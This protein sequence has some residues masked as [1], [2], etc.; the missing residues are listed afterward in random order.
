LPYGE[1]VTFW[2]LAEIVKAQAGILE[3]DTRE[4]AEA[5]LGGA[6][7][8]VAAD[9]TEA[10]WL[11][12]H[13][14]TLAGLADES[15][16]G[17]EEAF[18]AW[19][20]FL[21]AV[22]EERPLVLVF[23]DLH[24]ADDALL[25][26]VDR[27]VE[28]ASGVPLLV[29]GTA[30]PEL[31]QR[32]S[33][34]GG[35]KPNALT[36]SLSPLSDEDTTRLVQALVER[37][38]LEANKQETL[39]ARAGGN[40]LYAEQYAR[41]LAERGDVTDLPETVQAIIAARLDALSGDEKRLLQDAA[42]IGKVFWLGA[43]EGVGGLLRAQAEELL[44]GL[45]RKEFVQRSR[46]ASIAGESEYAF[47]HLLICDIAYGQ[48]PR[49]ERSQKHQRAAA[50]I[51]SL[52][53]S[54]DQAE[55]L[56]HH[57]LQALEL[58]EAAGVDAEALGEPARHA[59][60]DAG[61]RAAALHAVAAAERFY[62]AALRLWPDGDPE[63]AQLLLRRA[64]P[65]K[66]VGPEDS[67]RLVE[68]LDALL[69]AG[70]KESAAEAELLLAR[71]YW[72]A[73]RH[74]LFDEHTDRA[75]ALLADAP[76]SR[77]SALALMRRG[78]RAYFAGDPATA[79]ELGEQARALI[80]GLGWQEGL[81]QVNSNIGAAR[82]E[83][84][85]P[86]GLKDLERAIEIA[87]AAG[88]L[89]TLSRAYNSIAA[90]LQVLG[91]LD[92]AFEARM[93]GARIAER[94]GLLSAIRWFECVLVDHHY[95]RGDWDEALR[96]ADDFLA[97]V[98]AGESHYGAWQDWFMRAEIRL[99]RG[100]TAAALADA[101]KG[102]AL[103]RAVEDSQAVYFALPAGAHVFALA[104]E[105]EQAL[106][107]A[108]E[109]IDALAG[110]VD[111]QFGVINFP[112]A[113]AAARELGL[114]EELLAAV[115]ARRSTPWIEAL[116]AYGGGDYVRAAEVLEQIGSKPDEAEARL[117]AAEQ[118]VAEGR[119]AEADVQLQQALAFYRSVGA[120]RYVQDCEALLAASA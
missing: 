73:G 41:I 55:M 69:A 77:V 78:T 37:P 43:V 49:A 39:L 81:S 71:S 17:P 66:D 13:L 94:L 42:V 101:E 59:M 83:L 18:S 52:A 48:I 9:E 26:F 70:D 65:V 113:S 28:R 96:M 82:I 15:S 32:R 27:L 20:R 8:G 11:E 117:R 92:A 105:R 10:R 60:R 53:R 97:R 46:G 31:L 54:E 23:E 84:G 14:R 108:R 7:A 109:L 51:E 116:R 4:E 75:F 104:G 45:E 25:D 34:W 89:T 16:A 91:N 63:R 85:E 74:D 87:A 112:L 98:E 50:W 90:A 35:G 3:S 58:A 72:M 19:R 115:E 80:E 57:Y 38:L 30:R 47:G 114:T 24:W 88:A 93:E 33:S 5:K 56:A 86:G 102:L 79:V 111:V 62:D 100:E 120:T 106:P 21:E 6:V 1:G 76:P 44:Y 22:A 95:R 61:D 110:G 119:R 40:P 67:E 64:A 12:R 29:L 2:A 36:I 107:L 103:A 118:L 68:A 99:A